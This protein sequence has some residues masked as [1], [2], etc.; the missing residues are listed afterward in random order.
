M[1]HN[2]AFLVILLATISMINAVPHKRATQF[3]PCTDYGVPPPVSTVTI[4]PDPPTAGASLSINVSGTA[5]SPINQGVIISVAFLDANYNLL[6]TASIQDFC[7]QA[8]ISCPVA[9]GASFT[10]PTITTTAPPTI[11][12]GTILGINIGDPSGNTNPV[13]CAM[14][15]L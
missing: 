12:P 9:A 6:G 2:L 1:K 4:N 3:G 15:H 8:G 7:S 14:A 5:A 10:V 13:Q 11:N